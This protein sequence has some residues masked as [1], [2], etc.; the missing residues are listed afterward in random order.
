[1]KKILVLLIA[2]VAL[3]SLTACGKDVATP[4]S[5]TAMSTTATSS[6]T[7]T[8][9]VPSLSYTPK[10]IL[11]SVFRNEKT[12]ITERNEATYL[13]DYSV[14]NGSLS[15]PLL[16]TPTEYA[17]VDLDEDH[18]EELIVNISADYGA[19]LVLRCNGLDVFGYEFGAKVLQSLKTDGSFMG[20]N[21]AG[22]NYYCRLTFEGNE[23]SILYTAIKDS[24]MNR[25]ELNGE[26]C[27]IESLNEYINDWNL[28]EKAQ[29][30]PI[31]WTNGS[32]PP[33]NTV[34]STTQDIQIVRHVGIYHNYD[35]NNREATLT[36]NADGTCRYPGGTK[37]TWEIVDNTIVMTL[38]AQ[39]GESL[40]I[41]YIV[42]NGVILHDHF[43]QKMN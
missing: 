22:I 38:S 19:Y 12:F 16:A 28:K 29:W 23:K 30:T 37:G 6:V 39:Y 25:F 11:Q 42:N 13:K 20:S 4:T 8:Q 9:T 32:T 15:T 41:A 3:L 2:L 43:F 24:T 14:G 34:P 5:I 27:S 7:P 21:G 33:E 18:V 40:H 35:W 31:T 26:E 36:L 17:F 1:M 10:Y